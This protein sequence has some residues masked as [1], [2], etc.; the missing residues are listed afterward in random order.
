[1]AEKAYAIDVAFMNKRENALAGE[2]LGWRLETIVYL[3]LRRRIRTEEEDIYYFD[4]G[5]TEADFIVCNGNKATGVY[6]VSY[7]IENPK[8][9]RREVNGAITAAKTTKCS[10]VYILTDHQSETI[11]QNG[12]KIKAMPVWEW[13]VREG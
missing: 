3:E 7:N 5:N 4:N 11:V 1:M 9:R 6:Q 2:N 13:I 12:I 10:N 8:T